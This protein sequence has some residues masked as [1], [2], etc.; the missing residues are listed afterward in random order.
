VKRLGST[1]IKN[2][3]ANIVRGGASAAVAIALP[4]FLTRIMDHERFAA[5]SILLQIVAYIG[6]FDF[7]LQTALAR[8]LA[9]SIERGD[10]DKRDQL[11]STAFAMLS[12]AAAIA[13]SVIC[14]IAWRLPYLMPQFPTALVPE[15][16][17]AIIALAA[18]ASI[19]LPLS[20]F[21]GVLIGLHRNEYPAFAIGGS[22][23]LGACAVV[24]LSSV[25]TSLT[26]LATCIGILNL[27]GGI[28][29]GVIA[30]RLVPQMR[31]RIAKVEKTLAVELGRYC[32]TLTAWSLGMLLVS[33]LDLMIVGYFNFQAA[34]YYAI[35]TT[36]I[37]FFTGL[38]ASVFSA[39]L[40]PVAVLQARGEF[41][42][43]RWLIASSTQLNS[44]VTIAGTLFVFVFGSDLLTFWVGPTYARL[45][46][47][48][49]EIL[50][51]AQTIRL[52]GNAYGTVLVAMGLQRYGL[53][54]VLLEGIINI[55]LSIFGMALFGAAGVA[56]ATLVGAAFALAM[57][58]LFVMSRVREFE[59]DRTRFFIQGIAEPLLAFAPLVI[60]LVVRTWLAQLL[61]SRVLG[62]T[63]PGLV[64]ISL[65]GSL[66]VGGLR[67]T[68][69][70]R[71]I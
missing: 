27:L 50:L 2:A 46:L 34:G 33:G 14:I 24:L 38:N 16:R 57:Q 12:V 7:G 43:I 25:T 31:L 42:R 11:I 15:M 18:C 49:L 36:L 56:W 69:E 71:L 9:Q 61:H 66:L 51:V 3:T 17:G 60:W 41:Q 55:T 32:A 19:L 67:K 47:P 63:I 13:F 58:V 35:A 62:D 39:M 65:S 22:R 10:R 5:W 68:R 48:I 44:Y 23:I 21:T 64:A 6:Y 8:Y 37:A 1:V 28:V 4:H 26:L 70:R 53:S 54:P 45:S 30:L 40:T 59:M 20:T 52:M 29:Q